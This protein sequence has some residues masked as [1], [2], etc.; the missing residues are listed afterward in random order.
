[1]GISVDAT[2]C[3]G[4]VVDSGDLP[5]KKYDPETGENIYESEEDWWREI[6]GYKNPYEIWED[7]DNK[8]PGITDEDEERYYDYIHQWD[9]RYPMPFELLYFW[10]YD[11]T[12]NFILCVPSS[13]I[14]ADGCEKLNIS[15]IKVSNQAKEKFREFLKKYKIKK[16]PTWLLS[17]LYG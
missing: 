8:K 6:N 15:K 2:I 5:W 17:A 12:D 7:A 1:M 4:V 13:I 11:N 14:C 16:Q 10:S 3:F 9:K